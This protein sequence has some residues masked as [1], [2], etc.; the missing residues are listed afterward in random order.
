MTRT[1]PKVTNKGLTFLAGHDGEARSLCHP[2][3]SKW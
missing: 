3:A 2:R 1:N